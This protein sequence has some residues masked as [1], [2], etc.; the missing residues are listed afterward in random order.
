MTT[1]ER[2]WTEIDRRLD[3]LAVEYGAFPVVEETVTN[4]PDYFAHGVELVSEGWIGDAGAWVADDRGRTLLIRHEA[5]T[6]RWGTP[7]GGHEPGETLAE[8][9]RRGVHEG[10]GI[11]VRLTGVYRARRKTVV[12]ESDPDAAFRCSRC[13]SRANPPI[14]PRLRPRSTSVTTKSSKPGG[15]RTPRGASTASSTRRWTRGTVQTWGRR[16][17]KT[18]R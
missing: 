15:T 6:E 3:R 9:A 10:T 17:A 16:A 14:P 4:D 5:D 11:A 1:E 7:G 2:T 8:T 12:D 18:H 13:G